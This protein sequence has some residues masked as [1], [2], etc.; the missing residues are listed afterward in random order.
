MVDK[1]DGRPI[2]IKKMKSSPRMKRVWR[3]R[4]ANDKAL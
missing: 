4:M 2:E 3:W 1:K